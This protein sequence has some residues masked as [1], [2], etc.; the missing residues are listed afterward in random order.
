VIKFSRTLV[1]VVEEFQLGHVVKM[2][3]R[4]VKLSLPGTVLYMRHH[5]EANHLRVARNLVHVIVYLQPHCSRL[6][7][8]VKLRGYVP[9]EMCTS[10]HSQVSFIVSAKYY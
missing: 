8:A 7:V 1:N 9:I 6:Q 10:M 5:S 2:Q 3:F 4:I